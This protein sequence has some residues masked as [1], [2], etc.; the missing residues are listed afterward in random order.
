MHFEFSNVT[1]AEMNFVAKAAIFAVAA[2]PLCMTQN[3]SA[4]PSS[5][6]ITAMDNI[7]IGSRLERKN[8]T[9]LSNAFGSF[10]Q[11]EVGPLEDETVKMIAPENLEGWSFVRGK[12]PLMVLYGERRNGNF[13]SRSCSIGLQGNF[14]SLL[15]AI[16]AKYTVTK[17]KMFS[18]GDSKIAGYIVSLVG[19]GG[20]KY[21]MSVQANAIQENLLMFSLFEISAD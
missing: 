2:Y 1:G 10:Y 18:Q 21:A 6:A 17:P 13:I 3:C 20:R 19:M 15:N 16:E 5:I 7:C 11:Y 14:Q 4:E 8:I 9:K 12:S